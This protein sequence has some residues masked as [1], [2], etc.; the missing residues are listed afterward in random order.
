[1]V[2]K[3][4]KIKLIVL[5]AIVFLFVSVNKTMAQNLKAYF[6]YCTFYSPENGPYIET[7][8]SVEGS[9]IN[10]LKNENDKFQ[11]TI[12]ITYLFKQGE[13]IKKIQKI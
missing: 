2:L 7:Y 6:T 11:G 9:S 10:Y 4:Y 12:E 3:Y 8:L 13:E 5:S 1:M